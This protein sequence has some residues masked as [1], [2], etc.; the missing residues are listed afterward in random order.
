MLNNSNIHNN[1]NS[2]N[3]NPKNQ[4]NPNKKEDVSI[5]EITN[6][7]RV[8]SDEDLKNAPVLIIEVRFFNVN[9]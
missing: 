8:I 9:K 6:T 1:S 4:F 7:S 3:E 5:V 2:Q